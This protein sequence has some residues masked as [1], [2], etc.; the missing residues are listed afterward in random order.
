[1][2]RFRTVVHLVLLALIGALLAIDSS[3]A[4]S[5]PAAAAP[6]SESVTATAATPALQP[7]AGQ[8]VQV[9]NPTVV[10]AASVAAGG[11]VTATV[12]GAN[13]IPAAARR[14]PSRF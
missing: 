9:P 4:T 2:R 5:P 11:V 7:A 10:N 6:P 8:F 14:A 3:S 13:G 12:T 1:M